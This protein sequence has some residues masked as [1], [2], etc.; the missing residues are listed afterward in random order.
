[1]I[2]QQLSQKL[3]QRLSPQQIQLM[4]LLQ[5]PAG[6]L[7][8]RVRDEI[9]ANPALEE[10][11]DEQENSEAIDQ[12]LAEYID[13]DS[14]LQRKP[15]KAKQRTEDDKTIP[16]AASTTF[17]EHLNAQ[18]GVR[19]V[20]DHLQVL[21]LQ[22]IG[23][24]DSDG[25]LRRD[26]LSIV[27]DLAFSQN[28][29][30]TEE[31]IEK[32][33]ELVQSFDPAGVAARDLRE[34]LLLQLH[35][36]ESTQ[37]IDEAIEILEDH[38]DAFSKKHYDKLINA[39]GID[40]EELKSIQ[41]EILKLNPR[42]S[43]G[44]AQHAGLMT[45]QVITPDF[46][47]TNNEGI[48]SLTL[49]AR[50]APTLRVSQSFKEMLDAE[51]RAKPES[52][53]AQDA[54]VFVKRKIDSAK[55]FIDAIRQ[56][57]ITL[58]TTMEAIMAYQEDFFLTGDEAKLKPMILKDIAEKTGYDIST[59]SRVSNSKFVQTE[60]GT[61]KLKA[62]FSEKMTMADGEEISS[63]KVKSELAEIIA[64]EN[65]RKPLSDQKLMEVMKEKGYDIAR[66]TIAKYREQL[67]IP[68]ARLRKEL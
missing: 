1:M 39:L 7:E 24:L 55:W 48:L 64:N 38:F 29:T 3:L 27:N 66:R 56:R 21:A 6:S 33:V 63:K 67:D 58:I 5:I 8:E 34:C 47:I 54:L 2:R 40:D 12:E 13:E 30:T 60:F 59:I 36:K 62:L 16:V 37:S 10:G 65:K 28:L 20:D 68:V 4:K 19:E 44:F 41:A 18:L 26:N 51:K 15:S 31:E 43:S 45:H 11:K 35:R 14:Y 42:P 61:I 9:E 23:S 25:Y 32:A 52:K 57:Q 49:H 22:V 50:N 46:K 17:S 53:S